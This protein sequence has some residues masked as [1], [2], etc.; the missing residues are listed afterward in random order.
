MTTSKRRLPTVIAVATVGLVGA[1]C[2]G[3]GGDA[4]SDLDPVA[5]PA[6]DTTA[7]ATT[8]PPT[9]P[10]TSPGTAPSTSAATTGVPATDPPSTVD[11]APPADDPSATTDAT[12]PDD[13]L[14]TPPTTRPAATEPATSTAYPVGSVDP[15]LTPFVEIA[16]VDLSERLGIGTAEIDVLTAVLV[17]WPDAALGCPEPGLVYAQ[18]L[19]DGAVIELGVGGSVYRYHAGGSQTPF[20]CDRPLDPVPPAQT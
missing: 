7:P 12:L 20:P 2:Q 1:G 19:T 18:V 10:G 11:P 16:M 15:G 17:T 6:P 14:A 9:T 13:V 8:A 5:T 3:D 4:I